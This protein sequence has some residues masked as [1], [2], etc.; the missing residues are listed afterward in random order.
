[1]KNILIFYTETFFGYIKNTRESKLFV[2]ERKSTSFSIIFN[3][4]IS[5]VIDTGFP[6][7]LYTMAVTDDENVWMGGKDNILKLFDLQGNIQRTLKIACR[8]RLYICM[9]NGKVVFS[10]TSRKEIKLT[11]QDNVL[12]TLFQTGN[13][14]LETIWHHRHCIWSFTCVSP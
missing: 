1:M 8:S 6:D 3:V 2:T 10:D 4:W 7:L 9:H 11:S 5:S 13:W 12:L 14:K